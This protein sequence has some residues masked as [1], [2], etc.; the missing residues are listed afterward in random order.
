MHASATREDAPQSTAWRGEITYERLTGR[1]TRAVLRL[2]LGSEHDLILTF[3]IGW[4]TLEIDGAFVP[5]PRG[6]TAQFPLRD[7]DVDRACVLESSSASAG[8]GTESSGTARVDAVRV[9]G[10]TIPIEAVDSTESGN[11]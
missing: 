9:D 8:T 2:R 10:V 11:Q 3:G 6:R 1:R 5:I 4:K 7:G